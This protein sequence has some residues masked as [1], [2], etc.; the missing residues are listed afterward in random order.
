MRPGRP[1]V[2]DMAELT[3]IAIA[4]GIGF[5]VRTFQVTGERV[6]ICNPSGQVRRVLEMM[7]AGIRPIAWVTQT[8]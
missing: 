1:V 4:S 8:D 6:V 3:F 7:D 2:I 5:L